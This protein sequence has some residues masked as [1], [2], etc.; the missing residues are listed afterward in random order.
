MKD[1]I[2]MYEILARKL[3]FRKVGITISKYF[4]S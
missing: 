1:L 2:E 4:A 3:S